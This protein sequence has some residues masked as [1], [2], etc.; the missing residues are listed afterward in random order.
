MA[1]AAVSADDVAELLGE[2]ADDAIVQRI[3]DIGV[4]FEEV[5]EAIEDHDYERRFG[6]TRSASSPKIEEVRMILEELPEDVDQKAPLDDEEDNDNE[7]L[8]L[9]DPE[10]LGDEPQ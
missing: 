9:V 4:S 5:V 7:G 6:E 3:A 2:R 8:T 10:A 1:T